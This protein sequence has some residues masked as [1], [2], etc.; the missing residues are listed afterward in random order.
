MQD[1]TRKW[2]HASWSRKQRHDGGGEGCLPTTSPPSW[3]SSTAKSSIISK[4]ISIYLNYSSLLFLR[5]FFLVSFVSFPTILFF[6]FNSKSSFTFRYQHAGWDQ[7]F[8]H[9]KVRLRDATQEVMLILSLRTDGG[10]YPP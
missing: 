8:Q 3:F 4:Y 6:V 7:Y 1:N 2:R 9:L 10:F 5:L